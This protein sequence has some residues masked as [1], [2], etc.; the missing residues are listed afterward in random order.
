MDPVAAAARRAARLRNWT[1]GVALAG[2]FVYGVA[3][4]TPKAIKDYLLEREKQ[5]GRKGGT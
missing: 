1:V 2:L 3:A 5:K 4:N